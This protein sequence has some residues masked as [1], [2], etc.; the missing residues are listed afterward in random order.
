MK[1]LILIA[2]VLHSC[3]AKAQYFQHLYGTTPDND[4]LKSGINTVSIVPQS[5]FMAGG[6]FTSGGSSFIAAAFADVNG[7]ISGAPFF[8]NAYTLTNAS[9]DVIYVDEP[10]VFERTRCCAGFGIAGRYFDGNASPAARGGLFYL[11]LK[12][13][14][15]PET[16]FDYY[17]PGYEVNHL[18][19]IA[20]SQY[21]PGELYITGT[22]L[23]PDQI[24][25]PFGLRI[26]ECTGAAKW[27]WVYRLLSPAGNAAGR[28]IE[29]NPAFPFGVVS[30]AIV[31]ITSNNG[32]ND[33]FLMH[34]D[35]T[36]G[37]PIG[38]PVL[39]YGTPNSSD[40]LNSIN[41][42]GNSTATPGFVLGGSTN[43]YGS[44][45]F[46]VLLTDAAAATTFFSSVFDYSV[47]PGSGNDCFDVME[48][49]TTPSTPLEY[50]AVGST[51]NGVF[52]NTDVLVIKIDQFGNGVI[53]GEFTYGG[54]NND[55][56]Q[57]IDLYSPVGGAPPA[58]ISV[59]GIWGNNL[60][61]DFDM[62]LVKAYFNGVTACN[63]AINTPL[64]YLGPPLDPQMAAE[65]LTSN[66]RNIFETIYNAIN[67]EELC[68][69]ASIANGDNARVAREDKAD[70]AMLVLP[71][72][73]ATNHKEVTLK[74][75]SDIE[76][77]AAVEIY[78]ML[79]KQ[80]YSKKHTLVKGPNSLLIEMSSTNMA[81]G[82]YTVK[83]SNSKETK[84][85]VLVVK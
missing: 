84:T 50:Y 21:F 28:D 61:G 42:G 52:G 79:G 56:G 68:F 18:G 9:G 54:A 43:V 14:G 29:E 6:T 65:E 80:Y 66:K 53:N 64:Q 76:G 75:D 24:E 23:D 19:G 34:I 16:T 33:G 22:V 36:T 51:D 70:K 69:A 45:D 46:A 74:I 10:A 1:K 27:G 60:G 49:Y 30:A 44:T 17:F 39:I 31:G 26:N 58:G 7:N 4:I 35:A 15:T 67:D 77:P 82:M 20:K 72:P 13:D 12:D 48:R 8:N 11:Q 83:L 41:K 57:K 62:Y 59:Y 25:Y 3:M 81:P 78:D 40:W 85:V 37:L 73:T 47:S 71:N 2:L 63:Y 55:Y 32:Q 5:H 38:T